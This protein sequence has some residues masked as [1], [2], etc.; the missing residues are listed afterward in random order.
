MFIAIHHSIKDAQKWNET[1]KSLMAAMEQGSIPQGLKPLMYLPSS[2]GCQAHCVWEAE[3]AE[4]LKAFLEPA[5]GNV[6][7]NEYIPIN[8]QAAVGLPTQEPATA[9]A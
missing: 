7:Q 4:A 5:T 2:D 9:K 3:S 8:A 1:V 6:A